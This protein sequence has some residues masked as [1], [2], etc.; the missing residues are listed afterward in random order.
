MALS[1]TL[2]SDTSWGGIRLGAHLSSE[3]YGGTRFGAATSQAVYPPTGATTKANY[4]AAGITARGAS[5]FVDGASDTYVATKPAPPSTYSLPGSYTAVSTSANLVSALQSSTVTNIVVEN[6]VYTNSGVVSVGAA[7]QV[8]ARNLL[9]AEIQ[10]GI[11]GGQFANTNN[12]LIRGLAF[13]VTD[14]AKTFSSRGNQ[15]HLWAANSQGWQILDCTFLGNDS[16]QNGVIVE[17]NATLEGL[18]IQR[19]QSRNFHANG[20][21][22]DSNDK[23]YTLTTPP[24]LEDLY[25]ENCVHQLDPAGS[26]GTEESGLWLGCQATVN[27]IWAHQTDDYATTGP[28]G[29]HYGWQGL[30][31]GVAA[32]DMTI[33]DLLVTGKIAVGSYGYGPLNRSPL[34]PSVSSG[35][36]IYVN[37]METHAPVV[38]GWHQEWNG[39][40]HTPPQS[41]NVIVQDSYLETV[42]TGV[43]YDDGTCNSTVRRTTFVGQAGA[44]TVNFNQGAQANLYDTSGNDYSGIQVGAVVSSTAHPLEAFP[45]YGFN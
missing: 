15:I 36:Y 43:D 21:R 5:V 33:N 32:R 26:D 27:R 1:S 9:G 8:Y 3:S 22:I 10:F 28:Y 11:V 42:C 2:S 25:A 35:T 16:M 40:A 39:S 24:I 44:A 17:S 12:C 6:G 20:Y 14:P 23:T 30:W 41:Y 4:A 38:N 13:H 18:V 37:R 29:G 7:H 45:C 19:C 34:N 31:L